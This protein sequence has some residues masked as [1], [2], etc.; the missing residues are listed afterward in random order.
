MI[1]V[2]YIALTL[3]CLFQTEHLIAQTVE[4]QL[5]HVVGQASVS[6]PATAV[7]MILGIQLAQQEAAKMQA[8]LNQRS[9]QLMAFLRK[10]NV[11]NLKTITYQIQP[12]TRYENGKKIDEGFEGRIRVSFQLGVAQAGQ[13]L[14]QAL[15]N[16]ATN[17]E[18]VRFTA[19]DK[20][21]EDARQQA[22]AKAA[23]QAVADGKRMLE[24]LELSFSSVYRVD[25][26]Q[27]LNPPSFES[28]SMAFTTMAGS[29]PPADL[30]SGDVSVSAQVAV[31]LKYKI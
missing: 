7:D 30:E 10:A 8:A 26:Q 13:L 4:G 25:L 28:R 11:D 18:S 12:K 5:L 31:Q 23:K 29:P 6:L 9:Q 15:A 1:K 2:A 3:V 19:R 24:T 21:L 17:I 20:E 16:G 22:M 27:G 14:D